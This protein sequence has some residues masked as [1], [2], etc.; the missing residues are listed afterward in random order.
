M[1]VPWREQGAAELLSKRGRRMTLH[2]AVDAEADVLAQKLEGL[3]ETL[4]GGQQ[5]VFGA[6]GEIEKKVG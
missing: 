3:R 6:D 2:Q 4:G 1:S 5:S